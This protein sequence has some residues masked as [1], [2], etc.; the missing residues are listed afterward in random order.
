MNYYQLIPAP[1]VPIHGGPRLSLCWWFNGPNAQ[2]SSAFR[3]KIYADGQ[4]I[5]AALNSRI[6][7]LAKKHG[8]VTPDIS[9]LF[10]S[11][12][13]CAK[14]NTGSSQVLFDDNYWR[15]GHPTALGQQLIANMVLKSL[16][17]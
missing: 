14:S 11:N 16:G 13:L 17:Q 10:G 1:D 7:T 5:Q 8:A 12:G 2:P 3:K 9:N 4:V 6:A 15:S